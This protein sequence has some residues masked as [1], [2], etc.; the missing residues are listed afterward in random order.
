M[1]SR[2]ALSARARQVAVWRVCVPAIVLS[3][4]VGPWLGQVRGD[5]DA[6]VSITFGGGNVQLGPTS[7]VTLDIMG[8]EANE[9]DRLADIH[10][11]H[12]DGTL[13]LDFQ[14]NPSPDDEFA[15]LD[16]VLFD[17]AFR[18]I[19]IEGIDSARV[20]LSRL[21]VDGAVSIIRV[22]GDINGDGFVN[23]ADLQALAA[24]WGSD[25]GPPASPR[26]NPDADLRADGYINV[27]DLQVLL[28]NWDT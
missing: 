3:L 26:W 15:L 16:F 2:C 5:A 28:A 17:G 1:W 22:P 25:A 8:S 27:G 18:E 21:A 24:A 11:L 14:F 6:A 4:L 12:A 7:T 13:V 10:I 19:I 23:V 9:Y 20:D